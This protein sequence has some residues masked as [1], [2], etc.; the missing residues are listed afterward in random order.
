MR[1][2]AIH[3][4]LRSLKVTPCWLSSSGRSEKRTA[5]AAA[6][7]GALDEYLGE[8]HCAYGATDHWH[9]QVP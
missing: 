8:M 2:A 1:G 4:H 9:V 7:M 5:L 3:S 6:A